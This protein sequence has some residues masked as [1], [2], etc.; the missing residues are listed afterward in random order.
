M[1]RQAIVCPGQSAGANEQIEKMIYDHFKIDAATA[2]GAIL[3]SLSTGLYLPLTLS[4]SF[5]YER[6]LVF[7]VYMEAGVTCFKM[8]R[9]I[10]VKL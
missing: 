3:T 1:C 4:L 6:F 5:C 2:R 7:P 9:V 8:H 10:F